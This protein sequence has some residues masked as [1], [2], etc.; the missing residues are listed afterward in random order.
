MLSYD[1]AL[2]ER[3]L[4]HFRHV[5][6][7]TPL[8]TEPFPHVLIRPF[9]PE[10]LF[11][12][13]LEAMPSY[14]EFEAFAYEKH[15]QADGTSNRKRFQLTNR[16]IE[17]LSNSQQRFWM[18]IRSALG[19]TELK[20]AI[21]E[22]LAPGLAYRYGIPQDKVPELPG[23]ALPEVFH[24]TNGYSIAPHPDTRKKVVTMQISLSRDESQAH[25][26]TEFYRR[27]LNPMAWLREPRGFETV[28][29]MPFTRNTAYAFSVL[30]TIRLKSWHG[31]TTLPDQSGVRNSILN[32]WYEKAEHTNPDL[33]Q[34]Q[35]A[36]GQ[37]PGAL[38]KAA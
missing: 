6:G 29:R 9:F 25:L 8:E 22:K 13:L 17:R 5:V 14:E 7:A 27:S 36:L 35:I 15:Q 1:S 30:N 21:F 37:M 18:T 28:K 4:D 19:S 34:E 24:E 16:A 2:R 23:F 20:Q 11:D 10:R 3:I 31:R 33:I 26:G 12:D 32:I 38:R